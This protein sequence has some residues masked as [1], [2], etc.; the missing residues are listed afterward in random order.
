MFNVI[1]VVVTLV[2]YMLYQKW[3]SRNIK[4]LSGTEAKELFS[5]GTKGLQLI[6]V[7]T[8]EEFRANSVKGF[9]NMPLGQLG[10]QKSDLD[11]EKPTYVM[12]ASGSRSARACKVLT[13][14][15]FKDI[16][17]IRGGIVNYPRK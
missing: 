9:R 11:P 16:T 3:S 1:A 17:N 14:M 6:D 15:G 7:R 13:K 12:C 5:N 4:Q 10:V 2:L 8:P